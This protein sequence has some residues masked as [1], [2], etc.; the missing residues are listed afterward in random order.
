MAKGNVEKIRRARHRTGD[1]RGNAN[2]LIALHPRN[3]LQTT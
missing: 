3:V 2:G 1:H